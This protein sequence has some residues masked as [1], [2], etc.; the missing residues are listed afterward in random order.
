MNIF[1]Q[2]KNKK[3]SKFLTQSG[4]MMVEILVAISIIVASILAAMSVAQKSISMSHQSVHISQANFL[5]E[6]GAEAV[7]LTR[8]SSWSNISSLSES[9]QYYP[10]FSNTWNLST[11]PNSVGIF[12]RTVSIKNVN[13]DNTTGDIVNTGG[14]LDN[15]TKL[16]TVN[17]SWN[18]GGNVLS[19]NLSFYLM[20]IF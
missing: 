10:T 3:E 2:K 4:F 5:L 17:V 14:T 9:T 12:I 7:R 16:I 19:K 13:R 20:D 6:E 18:E 11:T 8:D 1:F 15:G